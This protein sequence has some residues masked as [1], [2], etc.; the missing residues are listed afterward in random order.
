M[1]TKQEYKE[2][3]ESLIAS[4]VDERIARIQGVLEYGK[5]VGNITA[6]EANEALSV[7][8]SF[9]SSYPGFQLLSPKERWS[10]SENQ[11]S[12]EAEMWSSIQPILDKA[13]RY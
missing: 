5:E 3:I 13:Q 2:K 4:S 8:S 11:S 1:I 9:V 7:F 6:E 12:E 10:L